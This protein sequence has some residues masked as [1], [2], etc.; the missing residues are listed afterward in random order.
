[1]ILVITKFDVVVSKVLFDVGHGSAQQYELA[2]ARAHKMYYDSC[3]RLFR[4]DPMALPAEIVSGTYSALVSGGHLT[5][6]IA[7]SEAEIR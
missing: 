1:M 4:K 5:P 6:P 2:R 7:L 3:H